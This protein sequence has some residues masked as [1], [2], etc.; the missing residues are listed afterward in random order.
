VAFD[1]AEKVL[2]V[3]GVRIEDDVVVRKDAPP[4][5]LT[6]V[7]KTVAEVEAACAR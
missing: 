1:R 3:G 6:A 2:A 4:R 5:N 7:P